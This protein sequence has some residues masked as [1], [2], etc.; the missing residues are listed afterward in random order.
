[1]GDS[2]FNRIDTF[3]EVSTV[4]CSCFV[5]IVI[6]SYHVLL[7]FYFLP[8]Q[9]KTTIQIKT[10]S[11]LG[12]HTVPF[13]VLTLMSPGQPATLLCQWAW[14]VSMDRKL[15]VNCV[16]YKRY[17]TSGF[18][19]NSLTLQFS[20]FKYIKLRVINKLDLIRKEI[21][22]PIGYWER[23]ERKKNGS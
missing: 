21:N 8:L 12:N 11:S 2:D 4:D 7:T 20:R 3:S 6:L 22:F 14:Y 16:P 15:L 18:L 17:G 13:I 9:R 1:V 5:A 23:T 19:L 10:S